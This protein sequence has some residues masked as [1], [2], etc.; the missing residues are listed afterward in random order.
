MPDPRT[1][2][3]PAARPAEGWYWPEGSRAAHYFRRGQSLCG[4]WCVHTS[5][6]QSQ[7]APLSTDCAACRAELARPPRSGRTP[8]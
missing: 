2:A 5:V 8:A 3:L 6:I 4:R 1:I 7:R